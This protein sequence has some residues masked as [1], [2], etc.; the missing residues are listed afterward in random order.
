MIE[1]VINLR[2]EHEPYSADKLVEWIKASTEGFDANEWFN[3]AI[4]VATKAPKVITVQKLMKRLIDEV[5]KRN[6]RTSH[7]VAGG[8]LAIL[9]RMEVFGSKNIPKV[10]EVQTRLVKAKLMRALPYS[11]RE[12]ELIEQAIRHD[13]DLAMPHYALEQIRY[14]YSLKDHLTKAEFETSQ[15]VYMRMAMAIFEHAKDTDQVVHL[16]SI[17]SPLNEKYE[18]RSRVEHVIRIYRHFAEKRLSAPTPNYNNLGTFHFGLA[19]CCVIAT[20]DDRFSLN[21]GDTV[22]YLMTTESA[23]LGNNIMVRAIG[24]AVRNG[25]FLHQGVLPYLEA[26]G[27]M[28]KANIQGGRGGA[29]NAYINMFHQEAKTILALRDP[30]ATKEYQNRD[31]H[32]A[33][34]TNRF[35]VSKFAN[36]EDIFQ[37]NI[38]TAPDLHKAFYGP[39]LAKFVELY[40][41]YEA[42]PTFEKTYV[43]ARDLMIHA[44][45]EGV[46][47]GS[48]CGASIDEM[49][50]NTPFIDPIRS[51]NLCLEVA[52][53]TQPYEGPTA[54]MDLF[55]DKEVGYAKFRA[56]LLEPTPENRAEN[57]DRLE[58]DC[59]ASDVFK[60]ENGN[61]WSAG[62]AELGRKLVGENG[63]LYEIDQIHAVKPEPEVALC[64]L[65][66]VNVTEPIS[67]EQYRDVM[68]YAYRM[69][70][71]AI[72]NNGYVMPHIGVTAKARRNAGVGIM[73]VATHMARAKL[74]YT[75]KEGLEEL[76]KLAERHYYYAVEA[77][78]QISHERGLAPWMHRS[79]YAD[80]WSPLDT[81]RKEIDEIADFKYYYD[82]AEQKARVKANGG[83]AFSALVNFMP[84]ESSS[85]ALGVANCYYPMREKTLLK[86]DMGIELRWSIPYAEDPEYEYQSVWDTTL[87]EQNAF[88]AP[89]AKWNDQASSADKWLDFTKRLIVPAEELLEAEIDRNVKGMKTYY[90]TNSR[91][92]AQETN[93]MELAKSVHDKIAEEALRQELAAAGI[94]FEDVGD[95][96]KVDCPGCGA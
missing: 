88:H 65:G 20:G 27:K 51:S 53:P 34:L 63:A 71:Y 47:A 59:K 44:L 1:S 7:E 85:K 62:F 14:K 29:A 69:I 13:L 26:Y 77:A 36:E 4:E 73:G 95:N 49:N 22:A 80:G 84:G 57:F 17:D 19:S 74:K 76:H 61:R 38:Y 33:F 83:L 37:W 16:K 60:D 12:W 91:M 92:P 42:D 75:T 89:F 43:S 41:K 50:R 18:H 64:S 45:N 78:L 35:F 24:D 28:S 2:G 87:L 79:K 3:I 93:S 5:L 66:S 55:S 54:M 40:E 46:K 81:Y 10:R 9:I 8:L 6:T 31:L 70:D 23:G 32:Y 72:D 94:S 52:L 96:E 25:A 68:Y 48:I 67:E 56:K 21:V 15:F 90:Y 86:T 58:V 11:D 30:R 82:H 39:D